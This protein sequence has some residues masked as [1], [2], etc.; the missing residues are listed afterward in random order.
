MHC[1]CIAPS[2]PYLACPEDRKEADESASCAA[3]VRASLA[4]Y[5]HS[6]IKGWPDRVV[7]VDQ[8]IVGGAPID[9]REDQLTG[10][11]APEARWT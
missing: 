6:R 7:A 5:C 11:T 9:L 2:R 3:E 4:L 8:D 10:P 1:D